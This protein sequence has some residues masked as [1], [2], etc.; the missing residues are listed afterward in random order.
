[1]DKAV[2]FIGLGRMG[3]P[4]ANRLAGAGH[5][6]VVF[7][8]SSEAMERAGKIE[9]VKLAPSPADVASQA[10]VLFTALPNNDI[11]RSVYLDEGGILAGGK[12]GLVTCD[13]S[14]VSP[15]VSIGLHTALAKKGIHHM[16]TTML[17][18]TPQANDGQIFFIVGGDEEQVAKIKPY[19]EAMGKAYHYAGPSGSSN[20][21]KLLQNILVAINAQAV[22]EVLGVALKAGVNIKDLYH[23]IVNGGG[24]GYSTYFNSRVMRMNSGTWDATFTLELMNKDVNLALSMAEKMGGPTEIMKAT[25]RAFNEAVKNP[26]WAKQDLSAVTHLME[27]KIGKKVTEG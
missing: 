14:T 4:M 19:L 27:Q 7:D 1:M 16:D 24:Q 13:C 9:G 20:W 11:V 25:Q 22:S 5:K 15:E 3:L 23:V 6:V 10:G 21:I 8:Q 26:E 2:G 18:S 17:G 12:K